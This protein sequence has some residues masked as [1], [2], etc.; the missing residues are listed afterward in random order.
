M[1]AEESKGIP[2]TLDSKGLPKSTFSPSPFGPKTGGNSNGHVSSKSVPPIDKRSTFGQPSTTLPTTMMLEPINAIAGKSSTSNEAAVPSK[3][4]SVLDQ[5]TASSA[6]HV[7]SFETSPLF[8]S[9]VTD[10]KTHN[11]NA[12]QLKI[13]IEKDPDFLASQQKDAASS[14][15][16]L[17]TSTTPKPTPFI[18]LQPPSPPTEE[19]KLSQAAP[20]QFSAS[21]DTLSPKPKAQFNPRHSQRSPMFPSSIAPAAPP[22]PSTPSIKSVEATPRPNSTVESTKFNPRA[23][24]DSP[25]VKRSGSQP[26]QEKSDPAPPPIDPKSVALDKL[27]EL[28]LLEDDGIM[29][30][31]ITFTVEPIIKGAIAQHNDVES[32]K[33]ASQSS[34][35]VFPCGERMLIGN[36]GNSCSLVGQKVFKD[37]ES[38]RLEHGSHAQSETTKEEICAVDPEFR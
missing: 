10:T 6:P 2:S 33:E 9:V 30:H 24:S 11:S 28:L 7:F 5:A 3:P 32:W 1:K 23:S 36:R 21:N 8:G 35:Y 12:N 14:T 26:H 25:V 20:L 37:V 31:F 16:V 4:K 29:Q 27:S 19:T 34:P 17:T 22:P 38:Q 18:Q 15:S 13:S